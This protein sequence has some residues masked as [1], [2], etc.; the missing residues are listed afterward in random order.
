MPDIGPDQAGHQSV[1][2]L[3]GALE[4]AAV[5]EYLN[6]VAGD[7]A[8]LGC[9]VGMQED[10]LLALEALLVLCVARRC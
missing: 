1:V 7:D 2:Q 9:V 3:C 6:Q 5:V 4:Q 10:A 8:A